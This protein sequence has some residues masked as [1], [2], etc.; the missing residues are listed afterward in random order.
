MVAFIAPLFYFGGINILSRDVKYMPQGPKATC[1]GL[2]PAHKQQVQGSKG[3]RLFRGKS[4]A[5]S[6]VCVAEPVKK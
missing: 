5:H 2:Y 1:P 6:K 3:R 4:S